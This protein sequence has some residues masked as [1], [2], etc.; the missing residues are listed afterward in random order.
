[1]WPC[2]VTHPFLPAHFFKTQRLQ[3]S[4]SSK[5]IAFPA[6]TNPLLVKLVNYTPGD[7][8]SQEPPSS[9]VVDNQMLS[10]YPSFSSSPIPVTR[11]EYISSSSASMVWQ[12][13]EGCYCHFTNTF[14]GHKISLKCFLHQRTMDASTSPTISHPID[15]KRKHFLDLADS[16]RVPELITA[17]NCLND[18]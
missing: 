11:A 8:S 16:V 15:N 10:L 12:V 2:R 6:L 4:S 18:D 3:L 5:A 7:T 14:F 9:S 1:L 13:E 17:L